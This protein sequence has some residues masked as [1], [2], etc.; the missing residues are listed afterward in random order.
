MRATLGATLLV[1][2]FFL[3]GSHLL[4]AI[5]LALGGLFCFFEAAQGWCA[6]RACG[7]KTPL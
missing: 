4:V 6:A 2:A 5:A 7:I 1:A 3:F